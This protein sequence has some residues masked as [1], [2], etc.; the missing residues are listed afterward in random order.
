MLEV[1]CSGTPYEIGHQ[2][3][4]AAKE[5]VAGSLVFYEELFQK[6]CSMNWGSVRQEAQ[7]YV[8]PLR[9]LSSRHVEELQ[10]LADG[11]GVDL[12]DIVAL[13]VRTE[14]T[15]S[16]YTVN[17]HAPIKTDGCTSLAYRQQNG[18]V[19]LAQNWDWQ[20]QQAPNL[21]ICH[22]SQPGT[23]IPK[24][25]MVTEGGV[26]GKIGI[27][28]SGVG[29]LLNAIRARGVD[30]TKLPIHLALRTALESTSA[31]AAANTLYKKGTAG[32]GH[33]LVSDQSE[34]I[35]L[36]CTSIGIKEIN[37]DSN[38]TV[39]HTNHLLLEHPGVDEPGWLPDSKERIK[40]ISE[41]LKEKTA[42]TTI[43]HSSFFELFQDEQGYPTSINRRQVSPGQGNAT[44][45]NINMDLAKRKAIVTVG[46]PTEWTERIELSP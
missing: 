4:T 2:H 19:L 42:S 35:G 15:F 23:D 8:E 20:L 43:D 41:L 38:G 27:N 14:I 29:T 21:F 24:I 34:A 13:N 12:L 7:K 5:K 46:R 31:R 22:I 25:S 28:S 33:I 6:T 18:E 10:G 3:G 40:R 39:A 16:L 32:S 37:M 11:A 36:E 9:K 44:L 1:H 45:F 17:P 26:I 30:N